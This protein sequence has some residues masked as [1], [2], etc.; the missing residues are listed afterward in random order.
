[1][2]DMGVRHVSIDSTRID[3]LTRQARDNFPN[4]GDF[5]DLTPWAGIRPATP[6]GRPVIDRLGYGNLIVN[7]GHGMLGFTLA[8]GSAD[9]AADLVVGRQSSIDGALFRLANA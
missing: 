6:S 8:M 7:I 2:V 3:T 4:A 1:M 9:L 5:G